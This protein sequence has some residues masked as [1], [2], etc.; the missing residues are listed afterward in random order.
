MTVTVSLDSSSEVSYPVRFPSEVTA[1][2][3]LR[4]AGFRY[5]H[6]GADIIRGNLALQTE[7]W[8]RKIAGAPPRVIRLEGLLP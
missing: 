4:A 3:W 1:I 5:Q 6:M 8:T 2:E 7:I